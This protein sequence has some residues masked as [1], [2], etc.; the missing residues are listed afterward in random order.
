[1]QDETNDQTW[2]IDVAVPGDARTEVKEK[3]KIDK[4]QVLGRDI[5][6]LWK[7]YYNDWDTCYCGSRGKLR[8]ISWDYWV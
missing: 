5:K 2:I 1:M 6:N 3:E 7:T 8:M 4:Y